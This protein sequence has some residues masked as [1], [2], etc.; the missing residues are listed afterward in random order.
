LFASENWD[1]QPDILC[2][3]KAIS[4]GYV[5]LS[6]TLAAETIYQRFI[7]QDKYFTHGSTHSGHPVSAAVGLAAIE[8]IIGEKLPEN[9]D[10]I[11]RYLKSRLTD[12][13][14]KH[15]IIGDV[16]G[17]GLMIAMELVNDR[18][19]KE[20]LPDTEAYDIGLDAIMRGMLFSISKNNFRLFPPLIIDEGFVDEMVQ[21]FDGALATGFAAGIGRKARLVAELAR[22]KLS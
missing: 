20:P 3:G 2:L 7:G 11:G 19:T 13:M 4:G 10:R 12:L 18:E 15:E 1:P 8:I 21:I 9:A 5:P 6:A 16:R 22:S 14:D 17:K